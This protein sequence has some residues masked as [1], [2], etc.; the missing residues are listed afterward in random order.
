MAMP[1]PLGG[2]TQIVESP[3]ESPSRRA[4]YKVRAYSSIDV[5]DAKRITPCGVATSFIA[6]KPSPFAGYWLRT[7]VAFGE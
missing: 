1:S 7:T 3:W 6:I 5:G 4:A 2:M